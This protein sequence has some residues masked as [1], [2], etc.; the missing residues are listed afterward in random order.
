[1]ANKVEVIFRGECLGGKCRHRLSSTICPPS[2]T[3]IVC[4]LVNWSVDLGLGIWNWAF[5]IVPLQ[6]RGINESAA[7]SL[8]L[9]SIPNLKSQPSVVRHR[10]KNY[11]LRI[12][13]YQLPITNYQLPITN[14][15]SYLIGE[16]ERLY[17]IFPFSI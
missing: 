17:Y 8:F 9:S 1:M 11:E 2:P 16:L 13:N 10:S 12:T 5:G 15:R 3:S 14:S 6:S 4:Q 7:R